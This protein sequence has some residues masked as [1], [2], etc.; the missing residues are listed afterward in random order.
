MPKCDHEKLSAMGITSNNVY[1]QCGICTK[2]ISLKELLEETKRLR[3]LNKKYSN[4]NLEVR[5]WINE[6]ENKDDAL[7]RE[8]EALK[9]CLK[10]LI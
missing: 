3:E 7:E 5:K 9:H 6:I 4:E 8:N 10:N 2:V 1:L